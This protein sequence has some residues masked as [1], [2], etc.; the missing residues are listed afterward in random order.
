MR[1]DD[2]NEG[3]IRYILENP[4]RAGLVSDPREYPLIGSGQ[5]DIDMVLEAAMLWTP[6]WKGGGRRRV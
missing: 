1:D 3:V 4:V 6:P 2:P 5:Y